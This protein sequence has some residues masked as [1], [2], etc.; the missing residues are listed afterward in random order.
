MDCR[1]LA[2]NGEADHAPMLVE[3]PHKLSVSVL[4]NMFKGTSSRML[5]QE[6]PDIAERYWGNSGL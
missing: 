3:Y 1:L 4:V 2:C 5:R 6:R